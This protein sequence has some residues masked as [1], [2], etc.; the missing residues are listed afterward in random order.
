MQPLP[1]PDIE[2]V[3]LVKKKKAKRLEGQPNPFEF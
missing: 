2:L 3:K 1:P